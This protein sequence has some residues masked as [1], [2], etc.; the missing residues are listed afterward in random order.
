MRLLRLGLRLGAWCLLVVLGVGAT[1]ALLLA[2]RLS[3]GP[4]VVT[5][6]TRRL[7]TAAHLPVTL[8]LERATIGWDGTRA[9]LVAPLRLHLTQLVVADAAGRPLDRLHHLAVALSARALLAGRIAPFSVEASGGV[10]RLHRRADGSVELAPGVDWRPHAATRTDGRPF[11]HWTDRL[12]I[13]AVDLS[14]D[15]A[16]T[17]MRW[18]VWD[19]AAGFSRDGNGAALRGRLDATAAIGAASTVVS[20]AAEPD[21]AGDG[22]TLRA[23]FGAV[24]PAALAALAPALLPLA[25]PVSGEAEA[26]L[27]PAG[28][29]GAL[30][31]RLLAGAGAIG[32]VPVRSAAVVAQVEPAAGAT[33]AAPAGRLDVERAEARLVDGATLSV[34]GT[35]AGGTAPGA[36]LAAQFTVDG[37]A[38]PFAAVGALWPACSTPMPTWRR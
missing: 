14:V 8:R 36:A 33:L 27:D 29:P 32:G 26:T 28:W 22:T 23:R 34:A 5:E 6:L 11:W 20:V 10:V 4:I 9:G 1:G 17:G 18:A 3:T 16:A 38:I 13:D 25:V 21:G 30:R 15:D 2:W 35:L 12:R 24:D 7:V 31:L 19:V 37:D